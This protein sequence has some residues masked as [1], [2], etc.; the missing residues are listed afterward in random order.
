MNWFNERNSTGLEYHKRNAISALAFDG[1]REERTEK[2]SSMVIDIEHREWSGLGS[3]SRATSV[4]LWLK[5]ESKKL[6][7]AFA[8]T[9]AE[10][11]D[12]D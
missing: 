10:V 1:L 3:S 4:E 11:I 12:W 9:R 5:T 7:K 6:L 8:F 2:V